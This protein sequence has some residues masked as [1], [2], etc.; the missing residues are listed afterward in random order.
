VKA[1][2][3]GSFDPPHRGHLDIIRRAARICDHLVVGI[4]N[5]PEKR[6]FLP[7]ATR[8]EI[9][10][11]E[12]ASLRNVEVVQ[13]DQAT[14]RW[15]EANGVQVLVRGLRSASDQEAESPMATIHRGLGYETLFLLCDPA[16]AHVSSR[17][18]RQVMAAGLPT[19][20]LITPRT[21]DAIQR[22]KAP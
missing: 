8:V 4:G 18:I 16:L 10:R 21:L 1:L 3:P 2:Y 12:C 20:D 15:A 13:Y 11:A 19:D 7:T 9:L 5:N 6:P 22:G 17:M 14:V